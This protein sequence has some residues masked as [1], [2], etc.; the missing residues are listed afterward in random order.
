MS[1]QTLS[2][3]EIQ[4]SVFSGLSRYGNLILV[5]G[6]GAVLAM[7]V[8][9]LPSVLLD[10]LLAL[11]IVGALTILLVAI[12]VTDSMKIASFPTLLLMATLFRLGLNISSTRAILTEG[13][14]GH[15]IDTFGH[16]ATGGNILVGIIMFLILTIIQFVVIAKGAE[17]V[18]EV[19]ARFTLDALPGKQM[20][21]DAD[22]RAGLIT[23]EEAKSLRDSLHRESKMYGSMDGAMKFVK[24]DAIAGIIITFINI[25]GGL[26]TGVMQRGL[27]FAEAGRTYSILTIGDGLVSQI[28]ALLIAITAGFVVTRVADEKA[29]HSL[30]EDIGLQIFSQP[31]AL[32]M[33]AGTALCMGL[34][35]G[36]PFALFALIALGLA[37]T[38]VYLLTT[39]QKRALAPQPVESYVI[40]T[41]RAMAERFG[42]A[43]PLALEVG[44]E[45]YHIFLKDP[46]WTHCLGTMVPKLKLYLSNQLGLLFPDLKI[47]VNESLRQTFRYRLRIYEV[48]VD[49]GILTPRHCSL[50]G[51]SEWATTETVHGTRVAL[52]DIG[53][54]EELLKK[55]VNAYGPDEM[56]LRH[57]ARVLKK[58]AGDFIG[59]QE[60]R[61]LLNR[62]DQHFPELVREVIPKMMSIQ[63]FTEIIKRLVEEG[64]PIKDFR[65][66]LQI[67]S[68]AQPESKDPVSLTE[69]V[70]IGLCR[71][72]TF[73]HVRDGNQLP[74]VT[75]NPAIEDEIRAAI[76]KNGSE[77]Y[78]AL[79]ADRLQ[80]IV[81]IFRESFEAKSLFPRQCVVLT[82]LDIRRYVRKI[83][84]EEFPDLPVLSFQELDPKVFIRHLGVIEETIIELPSENRT[85]LEDENG[86]IH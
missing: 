66:I 46:R 77:C 13:F 59:I 54:K 55:G 56:L 72:I 68:C 82:S 84:E 3:A 20:S 74:A 1:A 9:P 26:I 49:Y 73:L 17:R 4:Q 31:K 61:D 11:N 47:T 19:A 25:M 51:E 71:T 16:F 69:Q 81:S 44:S 6:I 34:I 27:T 70:R 2:L 39:I 33:S 76:Q 52:W 80:E 14:A 60:V 64:V 37:S 83:I 86:L 78:L 50:L 41:E 36:F 42:H 8:I 18:A 28:P 29:G 53:K 24:G 57:L 62:V 38:G 75:L 10:F 79:P 45:L 58:H 85:V 63:K 32:L 30:G 65:L 22:L 48:P 15:V 67:L 21:I 12:S 40:D 23:Q 43:V 7:M 5:V 35:P